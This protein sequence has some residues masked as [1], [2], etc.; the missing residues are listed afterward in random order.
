MEYAFEGDQ[1]ADDRRRRPSVFTGAL[2]EGLA[3]GDA[4]RDQDGWVSLNEL[5][6]YVFDK[7][8]EQNP[9]QTPSRQVELEG[10]LYL[11]RSRRRR[12]RPA[13]LPLDL[14]AALA[15]PNMFTRLGA[16]SELRSRL[17]SDDLP[18]AAG[19]YQALADLARNDSRTVAEPA[20]IAVS[21]AAVRPEEAELHFGRIEQGSAPPHRVIR[22]LG[23]PIAR[24]CAPRA[25]DDWIRLTEAAGGFD[26]SVS[27]DDAG[28]RRGTLDLKGPT[29]AAV[30]AIDVEVFS[31][32][33]AAENR[34]RREAQRAAEVR[35]RREAQQAAERARE[36]DQQPQSPDRVRVSSAGGS[37]SA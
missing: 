37:P 22:L 1:L 24:A 11:A 15:D 29:G 35:A 7:V 12:I 25:S 26:I 31:A 16:V 3:T 6:D 18:V 4:D 21:E 23:P 5:Y 17:I 13:P 14:Q 28:I 30:V 8:Q 32:G 9:H 10:E 34:G 33:R 36:E 19:A 20:A 27:T 2:V